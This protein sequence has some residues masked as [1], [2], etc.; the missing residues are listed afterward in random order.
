MQ[1]IQTHRKHE[2]SPNINGKEVRQEAG[3]DELN[4]SGSSLY[5]NKTIEF[6]NVS[7]DYRSYLF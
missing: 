1:E 3:G 4:D 6:C 5:Y 7:E 2:V